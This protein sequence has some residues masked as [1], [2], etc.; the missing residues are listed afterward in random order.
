MNVRLMEERDLADVIAIWHTARKQVHSAMGIAQEREM[1]L[2]DSDRV[3][4]EVI[5]PRTE[6]WVAERGNAIEGFVALR[7]SYVDRIYVRPEAQRRGT[8]SA[9]LH[10]ARERSPTGLELH[11]HQAN[12]AARDFYEKHAFIP[13][14]FGISPPPESEPDVEYHWRPDQ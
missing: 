11:T 3:F 5:A 2:G 6:I 10:K 9:L 1:T 13:V 4:R 7:G 14:A 8:G 12:Q